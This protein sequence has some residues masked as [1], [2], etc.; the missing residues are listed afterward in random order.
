MKKFNVTGMN[1][2][3]CSARVHKA[4]SSLKG[5]ESC[6]VN[7]LTNS[8]T[9]SGTAEADAV[10]AAVKAAGYG[11]SLE[12]GTTVA[13]AD[14]TEKN[15]SRGYFKRFISSAAVLLLLLY[16]TM[17]H[18]MLSFPLPHF[19]TVRPLLL[20]IIQM[21]LAVTIMA[22]NFKIYKNGFKSLFRLSPNM[23]SLVAIGSFSAFL[24]SVVI[25]VLMYVNGSAEYL[26]RL[27]FESAAMVPTLITLGKMLESLAKGKTSDSL[28]SLLKL[29]PKKA[30]VIRDGEE[31]YTDVEDVVVGDIFIVKAGDAVPVDGIV[32]DGEASIDE[33]ALTGES[34]TVEKTVDSTV[35][36][37]TVNKS[38]YVKCKATKV[39][40]DT[41]FGAI[42]ETVNHAASSKAPIA[43]AADKISGVFVPFVLAVAAVTLITWLIINGD[44]GKAL[45]MAVSVV[46]VSCPCALGLATPVAIMV[47]SGIAA[48]NGVLFKN[49]TALENLGKV[50][51]V[52]FD[53]TGTLTVG[54]PEV[55]DII[56]FNG[57]KEEELLSVA[58]SLE[59]HSN[60]PIATAIV[61][62]AVKNN[63]SVSVV[64]KFETVIGCGV[65]GTVNGKEYFIGKTEFISKY[66]DISE[67]IKCKVEELANKA[68][69]TI[70]VSAAN[71]I[72]G[73][74]AAADVIK[75][76]SKFAVSVLKKMGINAVMISGDNE[77]TANII[78]KKLGI[79]KVYANVLPTEKEQIIK[80]LKVG[81]K[82]VMVGDGVNDAPALITAD[83]GV[84]IGAGT[85][86]AIDSADVVIMRN[87][88][89]DLVFAIRLSKAVIKNIYENLFWAFG[90]NVIGIPLAAGALIPIL[91]IRLNPMF[92]A[93]AMS[94]SSVLVVTNA[95]RLNLKFKNNKENKVVRRVIEI[96]GMM[97]PHCEARVQKLLDSVSG[98]S[99]AEVSFKKGT[100]VIE[101]GDG[102]NEESVVKLIENE[103]Y[104]VISVK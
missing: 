81:G 28:K 46:V 70:L 51:T 100:A 27:Y 19:I 55:T 41:A 12:N 35:Y 18:N 98:I 5:V 102:Y 74:I 54:K 37:A 72:I 103:S 66:L 22:I 97:C 60:H 23:D 33:S 38:G 78:A 40:K 99:K 1:C 2:A 39:G 101:V 47:G 45:S 7:L 85:D 62:C 14:K 89:S 17:G 44:F 68:K 31:L 9:V 69:T 42:I 64:E 84:A 50:K 92:G 11:A 77:L 53:K 16:V 59:K 21:I 34:I 79:D 94:I 82:T 56:V 49:A 63:A 90:Y 93:A 57:Y 91:G 83:V 80:E 76:D 67:E 104:K 43:R 73:I 36:A 71:K 65:K 13:A 58:A 87:R 48:K 61:D 75:E 10:I 3:A 25:T 52:A 26:H 86:V 6:S 32:I 88:L 4:V 8:M 30:T 24:Y 20:A 15:V 96:K 95:L 29:S